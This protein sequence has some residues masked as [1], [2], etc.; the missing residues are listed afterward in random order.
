MPGDD[1]TIK[2][3]FLKSSI[4]GIGSLMHYI[5]SI[6]LSN[7][8]LIIKLDSNLNSVSKSRSLIKPQLS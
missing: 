8:E 2:Y 6:D 7:E 1:I 5:S 3:S 4:K